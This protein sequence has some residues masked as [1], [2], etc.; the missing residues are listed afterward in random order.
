MR[1]A[2]KPE[3]ASGLVTEVLAE[4]GEDDEGPAHVPRVRRNA[5]EQEWYAPAR[6][7]EAARAVLGSI[8]LDPARSDMAWEPLRARRYFTRERDGRAQPRAD[9]VGLNPPYARDVMDAFV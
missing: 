1:L 5:G 9:R 4:P 7:L 8:D 2:I 3:D 6:Y